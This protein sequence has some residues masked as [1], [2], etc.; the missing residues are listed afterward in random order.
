MY[1]TCNGKAHCDG[2]VL[3]YKGGKKRMEEKENGVLQESVRCD[4]VF[5]LLEIFFG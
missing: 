4:I 3:C 1:K 5:A 2:N